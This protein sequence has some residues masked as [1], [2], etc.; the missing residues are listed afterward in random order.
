MFK[1]LHGTQ[2]FGTPEQYVMFLAFTASVLP[3]RMTS[4]TVTGIR[5]AA[6]G[7]QSAAAKP[8]SYMYMYAPWNVQ[9]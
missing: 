8:L 2:N 3:S 9:I 6:G 5:G 4:S 1:V 7:R